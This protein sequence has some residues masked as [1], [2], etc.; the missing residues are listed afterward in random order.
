M[1]TVFVGYALR[2]TPM[3]PDERQVRSPLLTATPTI[4]GPANF[5]ACPGRVASPERA[6]GQ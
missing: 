2:V 3:A 1:N 6:A 4:C 5:S